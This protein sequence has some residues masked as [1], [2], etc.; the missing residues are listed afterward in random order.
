[1]CCRQKPKPNN[2]VTL[3]ESSRVHAFAGARPPDA[4]VVLVMGA[5]AIAVEASCAALAAQTRSSIRI[6][7]HVKN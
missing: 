3:L 4:L 2:Y 1:M 7:V 5:A 6:E